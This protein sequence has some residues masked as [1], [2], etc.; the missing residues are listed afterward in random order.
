VDATTGG[1]GFVA[2][3]PVTAALAQDIDG[4]G[5]PEIFLGREDGFVNVLRLADGKSIGLLNAGQS[6]LGIAALQSRDGKPLL[7]VGIKFG[8]HVFDSNLKEIG[9]Y[10]IPSVAFAGPGGKQKDRV[11]VVGPDGNVTVLVVR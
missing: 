11:F 6:I 9:I 5:L 8:V 10:P 4:D 3:V 7:A 2:G 1:W